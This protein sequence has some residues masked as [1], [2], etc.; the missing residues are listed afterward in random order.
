[1]IREN[2]K[3]IFEKFDLNDMKKFPLNINVNK[4]S[5]HTDL[6]KIKDGQLG[7]QFWVTYA[8]CGSTGKDAVRI[9]VEQVDVIRRI[10]QKHPGYF[11]YVDSVKGK[12]KSLY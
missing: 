6:K 9:H 4:G 3:N 7:A 1:M 5:S 11:E 10:I 8:D 12:I 2:F